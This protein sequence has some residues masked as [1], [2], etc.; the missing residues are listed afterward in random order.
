MLCRHAWQ[1]IDRIGRV[2]TL[3]CERCGKRKV[4]IL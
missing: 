2:V 4:R 3:Q 1:E